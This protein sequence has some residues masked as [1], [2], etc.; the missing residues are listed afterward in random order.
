[1]NREQI[2]DVI[3]AILERNGPDGHVDGHDVIVDFIEA[4]QAGK[5]DKWYKKYLKPKRVR[6]GKNWKPSTYCTKLLASL[7]ELQESNPAN[8]SISSPGFLAYLLNK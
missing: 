1:M 3:C 4:L 2:D 6:R 5:A 8:V 7:N